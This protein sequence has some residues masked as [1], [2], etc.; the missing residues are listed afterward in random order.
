MNLIANDEMISS[1]FC[2]LFDKKSFCLF[3]CYVIFRLVVDLKSYCMECLWSKKKEVF[4]YNFSL[5]STNRE[6]K[7]TYIEPSKKNKKSFVL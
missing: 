6:G 5:I 3:Y 2:N 7:N 4:V 1:F